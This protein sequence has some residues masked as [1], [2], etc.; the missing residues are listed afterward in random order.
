MVIVMIAGF[1][2]SRNEPSWE[3]ECHS[4]GTSKTGTTIALQE[5]FLG[6]FCNGRNV[7]F[8]TITSI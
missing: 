6:T 8:S 2:L 1:V 5:V 7:I 3:I 4:D